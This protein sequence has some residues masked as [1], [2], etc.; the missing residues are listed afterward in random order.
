MDAVWV[1][2]GTQHMHVSV[3]FRP[4]KGQ[5]VSVMTDML[6][7]IY[8]AISSSGKF[9]AS[10]HQTHHGRTRHQARDENSQRTQLVPLALPML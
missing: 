8:Q 4:M 6:A 9:P 3:Y 2:A 10:E 7:A 5:T 1:Y